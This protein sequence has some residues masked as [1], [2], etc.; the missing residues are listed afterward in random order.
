VTGNV[1]SPRVSLEDGARFK[2]SIDMD[3]EALQPVFGTG[4]PAGS[5]TDTVANSKVQS[6]PP[7]ATKPS[8]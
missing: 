3:P 2:G 1:M 8:A 7:A 5:A 4:R 6:A